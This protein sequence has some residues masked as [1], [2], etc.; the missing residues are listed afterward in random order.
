MYLGLL[1]FLFAAYLDLLRPIWSS[2]SD[3]E[4]NRS[5]LLSVALSRS[6]FKSSQH[7]VVVVAVKV[8]IPRAHR[9]E[10]ATR[11]FRKWFVIV[12]LILCKMA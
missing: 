1:A 12:N 11:A 2:L 7:V 3:D 8:L 9:L 10:S 4:L 6:A 5:A